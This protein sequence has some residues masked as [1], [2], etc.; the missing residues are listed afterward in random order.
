MESKFKFIRRNSQF[1]L[2]PA[3]RIRKNV[4]DEVCQ[5]TLEEVFSGSA[6]S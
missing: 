1:A 2:N 4:K 6:R 5:T 3:N